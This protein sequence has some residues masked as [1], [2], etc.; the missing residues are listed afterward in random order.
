MRHLLIFRGK[1]RDLNQA[2]DL[3][4]VLIISEINLVIAAGFEPATLCLEGKCSIQLSYATRRCMRLQMYQN[5]HALGMLS[6][7]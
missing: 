5:L 7:K 6:R 1:K 4:K 3:N 2:T